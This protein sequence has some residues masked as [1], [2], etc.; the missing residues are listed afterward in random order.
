MWVRGIVTT[1]VTTT[2]TMRPAWLLKA[3]SMTPMRVANLPKTGVG[4]RQ[5]HGNVHLWEAVAFQGVGRPTGH[6]TP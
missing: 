1:T 5:G 2:A 6:S 4:G 3:S